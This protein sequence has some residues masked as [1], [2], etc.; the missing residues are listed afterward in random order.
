MLKRVQAKRT[1]IVSTIISE[2]RLNI[3]VTTVNTQRAHSVDISEKAVNR[4]VAEFRRALTNPEIDPRPAGQ[5]LYDILVKPIE[6]ELAGSEADT[7]LWSLDGALRYISPAALWDQQKGYLVERF[8]STVL[9]L[10]SLDALM[11]PVTKKPDWKV[12]GVGVSK[13]SEGFRALTAV[14]DELDCIVTDPGAKTVSPA[15]VCK[16]GVM[17]GRKLL[18]E[19]FTL[20]AFENFL[21]QYPIIHIASHFSLN[22]G[23]YKDSFLL[24][25]GGDQKRFTVEDLRRTSLTGVELI[26]F[27]ACNTATPGSERN[28]GLEIE[29]FSAIAQKQGAKTVMATLWPVADESTRDLMVRFYQIYGKGDVSK[30]G[31]I[32]QAQLAMIY[33]G[34]KSGKEGPARGTGAGNSSSAGELVFKKDSGA[35]YSHPYYWSPFIMFGNWQ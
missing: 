24:L 28:N 35:P 21:K 11:P 25:G 1:V 14:P 20:A 9:T 17:A 19:K 15:P 26:V 8:A 4:L 12:L 3:I 27:S 5:A 33:G 32:R 29:G 2:N 16:S 7:I 30:A 10:S 13:P 6:T 18:D 34:Y 22:P 23:N 31:A